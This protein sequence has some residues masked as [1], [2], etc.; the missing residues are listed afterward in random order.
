MSDN[1]IILGAIEN[2][3]AC[4]E[5]CHKAMME[6]LNFSIKGLQ[7]KIDADMKVTS[8]SIQNLA[9]VIQQHNS[10]LRKAEEVITKLQTKER[11]YDKYVHS[12]RKILKNWLI[13]LGC[14]TLL[15]VVIHLAMDVGVF[16]I[17][18]IISWI[19]NKAV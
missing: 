10:R 1:D 14:L 12:I 13:V 5:D 6:N 15:I 8:Q 19:F 16:S 9:D 4:N 2:L 17:N 11:E 18:E 7:I 3:R